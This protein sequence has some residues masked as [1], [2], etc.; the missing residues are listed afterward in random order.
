MHDCK[1]LVHTP[2]VPLHGEKSVLR[3]SFTTS[4][5]CCAYATAFSL[6]AVSVPIRFT[7]KSALPMLAMMMPAMLKAIITSM[8][9]TPR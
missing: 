3:C 2:G 7:D 9:L 5:A 6:F 1:P 8:T 4:S